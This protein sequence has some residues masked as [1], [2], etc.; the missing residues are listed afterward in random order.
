[1]LG[2]MDEAHRRAHRRDVFD[3]K[4]AVF[5]ELGKDLD[6]I[7]AQF[8]DRERTRFDR[9]VHLPIL[10][11]REGRGL[12]PSLKDQANEAYALLVTKG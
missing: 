4:I 5:P 2:M 3:A 7:G 11:P 1:M 12:A 8:V 6:E 10:K 9:I